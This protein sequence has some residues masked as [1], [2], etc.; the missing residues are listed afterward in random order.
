MFRTILGSVVLHPCDAISTEKLME[1]AARHVGIVYLRTMRQATPVIYEA[2]EKF[3][4]GGSKVLRENDRDIAT[5]VA[6]GAT[7]H[8]AL[9]A[10]ETL[11]QENILIRVIDAYSIKPL[12]EKTIQQAAKK[13]RFVLTVEDHFAE[14]GLGEAVLSALSTVP[15]PV[16]LLAVR[17]KPKSGKA[18][19]LRRFESISADAIVAKVK[20]LQ[21]AS[22]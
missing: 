2:D 16:Y 15:T 22:A 9:K 5:V 1:E 13:T 14:G 6:A 20:E 18:D 19:E 10:C 8:E 4:I 12:D 21:D 3:P 11:K 17:Q 7:I